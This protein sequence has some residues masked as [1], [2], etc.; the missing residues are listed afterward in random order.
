MLLKEYIG[1]CVENFQIFFMNIGRI[2]Y[3][4]VFVEQK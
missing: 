1:L 4:T 2:S 3:F